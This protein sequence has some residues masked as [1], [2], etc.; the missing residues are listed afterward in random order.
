[1]DVSALIR[2]ADLKQRRF[3]YGQAGQRPNRVVAAGITVLRV[4]HD[5]VVAVSSAG[6]EYANQR[7]VIRRHLGLLINHCLNNP[8]SIQAGHEG[9]GRE[10]TGRVSQ[11]ISA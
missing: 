5:H 7:F 11:E 1:K 6:Q 8:E 4:W 3:W 9:C 10:P 2:W